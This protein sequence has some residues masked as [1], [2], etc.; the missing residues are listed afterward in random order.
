MTDAEE[1]APDDS[2]KL[3]EDGIVNGKRYCFNSIKRLSCTPAGLLLLHTSLLI[4]QLV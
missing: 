4:M 1:F 3:R 2:S